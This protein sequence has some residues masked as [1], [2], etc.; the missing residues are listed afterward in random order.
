MEDQDLIREQMEN[1]RSALSEKLET[2]EDR[3]TSTVQGATEDVTQTVE[4]VTDTVQE[5]VATV[6]ETVQDTVDTVKDTVEETLTA[7]KE[8]VSAV[9]SFFDLPTHVDR[10]P[11]VAVGGS[12]AVGYLLGEYLLARRVQ[13]ARTRN[14]TAP[15]SLSAAA[16]R[17]GQKNGAYHG[18][19]PSRSSLLERFEPELTKLKG[20]ALGTLMGAVREMVA[21]AAGEKLGRSVSDIIDSVTEKLGGTPIPSEPKY[22]IESVIP[23]ASKDETPSDID[24]TSAAMTV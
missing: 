9:K 10:H 12:V 17:N 20:L 21:K 16:H 2:L 15:E 23:Y 8:G 1:T 4:T 22:D 14:E 7:V 24:E 19:E 13:H 5:T 3:V 11:W 18:T 6:K